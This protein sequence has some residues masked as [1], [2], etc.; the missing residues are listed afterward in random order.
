MLLINSLNMQ[1]NYYNSLNKVDDGTAV[2]SCI[3]W[4][5]H[6]DVNLGHLVTVKGKIQDYRSKRQLN[7]SQIMV[8]KDANMELLRIL[9]TISNHNIYDRPIT[10]LPQG[11]IKMPKFDKTQADQFY[12]NDIYVTETDLNLFILAWIR[13]HYSE[14]GNFTY[15][16]ILQESK[17]LAFA[18]NVLKYQY[19]DDSNDHSR[20]CSLVRKSIL[21]LTKQ[22]LLFDLRNRHDISS[23]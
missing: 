16:C 17:V 4:H 1:V 13:D 15:D 14:D 7:I 3:Q 11:H 9:I 20:L 22:G 8:E 12:N 2:L 18:E 6:T 19:N 10:Q 21:D 5:D 23:R